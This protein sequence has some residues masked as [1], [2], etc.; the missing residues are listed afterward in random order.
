MAWS[1]SANVSNFTAGVVATK[2]ELRTL[3]DAFLASQKPVQAY[4]TAIEHLENLI[5]KFPDKADAMRRSVALMNAEMQKTFSG[6]FDMMR[7]GGIL[8]LSTAARAES[9]LGLAQRARDLPSFD[10]PGS[11]GLLQI[12]TAARAIDSLGQSAGHSSGRLKGLAGLI[13]TM[14]GGFGNL[15]GVMKTFGSAGGIV[16][17]SALGVGG[18]ALKLNELAIASRDARN[19]AAGL[20]TSKA[21]RG[22]FEKD[23]GDFGEDAGLG[24]GSISDAFTAGLATW[25]KM[26][27]IASGGEGRAHLKDVEASEMAQQREHIKGLRDQADKWLGDFFEG[28]DK[29]GEASDRWLGDFMADFDSAGKSISQQWA[30]DFVEGFEEAGE[31]SNKWLDKFFDDFDKAGEHTKKITDSLRLPAEKV[32]DDLKELIDAR[33]GGSITDATFQRGL[34]DLRSKARDMAAPDTGVRSVAA[35]RAGTVE[36]LRASTGGSTTEKQLEEQ[37][38]TAENTKQAEELLVQIRDAMNANKIVEAL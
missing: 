30:R 27:N 38:K 8:P 23:I 17:L 31:V 10:R 24:S 19:E 21:I 4:A 29:A 25:L 34:T 7:G 26:G 22:E 16:G 3:K 9:G 6:S 13:T 32:R 14:T 1:I 11:G 12:E 33:K 5:T 28:F 35:L 36:A 18:L 37:K 2:Q 15:S 20:M